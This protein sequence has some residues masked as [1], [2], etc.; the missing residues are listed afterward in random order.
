MRSGGDERVEVSLVM[1][2][3]RSRGSGWVGGRLRG[4][5]WGEAL[6]AEQ[7]RT[8]QGQPSTSETPTHFPSAAAVFLDLPSPSPH[9][10]APLLVSPPTRLSPTPPLVPPLLRCRDVPSLVLSSP[11]GGWLFFLFHQMSSSSSPDEASAVPSQPSESSRSPRKRK[12]SSRSSQESGQAVESGD[13]AASPSKDVRASRLVVPSSS[14]SPIEEDVLRGRPLAPATL[15]YFRAIQAKIDAFDEQR[16][17]NGESAGDDEEVT[18]LVSAALTEL[19]GAEYRL[20]VNRHGSR[21]VESLIARA[22]GEQLVALLSALLPTFFFLATDRNA[23]HTLE[24]LL[25]RLPPLLIQEAVTRP[26]QVAPEAESS[27]DTSVTSVLTALCTFLSSSPSTSALAGSTFSSPPSSH[28]PLLLCNDSSSHLLRSLFLLLTGHVDLPPLLQHFAA[29]SS[30]LPSSSPSSPPTSVVPISRSPAPSSVSP[31]LDFAL[32]EAVTSIVDLKEADRVELSYHS[33][34]SPTLQCLITALA[35]HSTYSTQLQRLLA[36][37]LLIDDPST[38]EVES[39]TPIQ[40][41]ATA[42]S[43]IDQ[44]SRDRVGS[45]LM[46]TVLTVSAVTAVDVFESVVR[47][48]SEEQRLHDLSLHSLGNHVVQRLLSALSTSRHRT[49]LQ[50]CLKRLRPHLRAYIGQRRPLTR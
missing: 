40:L 25:H 46:E 43:H 30:S 1:R 26:S 35:S 37:L 39:A 14:S 10:I 22:S 9:P 44:L 19:K 7:N 11:C 17:D 45:H 47:C 16:G 24:R 12:R 50:R 49:L 31:Q 38:G 36:A 28:W 21:A 33:S 18:L 6:R 15:S 42:V 2:A 4:N 41:S 5:D 34:A 32:T 8:E 13:S 48:W 3:Q 27:A 29:S 23:S 20:L